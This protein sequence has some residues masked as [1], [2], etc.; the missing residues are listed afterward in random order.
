VGEEIMLTAII[1]NRRD[2]LILLA[3]LKHWHF[4]KRAV[5][6]ARTS[7]IDKEAYQDLVE[8]FEEEL[9]K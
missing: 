2:K 5:E 3:A 6:D 4:K 1:L 8:R 9:K 7:Y